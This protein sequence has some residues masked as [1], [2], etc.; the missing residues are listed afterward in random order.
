MKE[1]RCELSQQA[2]INNENW[3]QHAAA[4]DDCGQVLKVGDWMKV[5]AAGTSIPALPTPGFLTVKARVRERQA[6]AHKATRPL[7]LMAAFAGTILTVSIVML[8]NIRSDL[9]FSMVSAVG[10]VASYSGTILAGAL[11][12]A[13]VCAA[14][15]YMM[16]ET[17]YGHGS[18]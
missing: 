18:K 1:T 17:R 2:N 14:A 16:N 15:A 3:R 10:M 4:C 7:K 5:F 8:F 6:A 11:L 9:A 13:V 12:A